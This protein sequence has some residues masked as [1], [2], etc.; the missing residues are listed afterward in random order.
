[1]GKGFSKE[2]NIACVML[3]TWFILGILTVLFFKFGTVLDHGKTIPIGLV[4]NGLVLWRLNRLI[5]MLEISLIGSLVGL[6]L[7]A[8]TMMFTTDVFFQ[9]TSN[10]L[11]FSLKWV[12]VGAICSYFFAFRFKRLG[13]DIQLLG[14]LEST[15]QPEPLPE[16]F[17]SWTEIEQL[18][19]FEAQFSELFEPEVPKVKTVLT[20]SLG[21][22]FLG[23]GIVM[24]LV[25]L[26][27]QHLALPLFVT[28]IFCA[29]LPLIERFGRYLGERIIGEKHSAILAEVEESRQSLAQSLRDRIVA[30]ESGS[31]TSEEG[32]NA[33]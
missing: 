3:L 33:S 31:E 20:S 4:I 17:E 13:D 5:S 11:M 19:F 6:T 18:R 24:Y 32:P 16:G 25:P 29:S 21:L 9:H 12:L 23:S 26:K 15:F 14:P 1:M 7:G 28:G 30:L 27:S 22:V 10:R 2:Q 8:A